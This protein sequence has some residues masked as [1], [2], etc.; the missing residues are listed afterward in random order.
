M[1]AGPVTLPVRQYSVTGHLAQPFLRI[2]ALRGSLTY[3]EASQPPGA[4]VRLQLDG[5]PLPPRGGKGRP[6]P[7]CINMAKFTCVL[8]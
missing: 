4:P 3:R 6:R 5:R 2:A 8:L 7:Y 1:P